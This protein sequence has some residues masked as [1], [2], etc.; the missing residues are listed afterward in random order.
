[1]LT[2]QGNDTYSFW[3]Q[4]S[5]QIFLTRDDIENIIDWAEESEEFIIGEKLLSIGKD[6]DFWKN[7]YEQM[8]YDIKKLID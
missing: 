7:N 2:Y 5:Q 8:V 3:S 6:R 1:M 4:S